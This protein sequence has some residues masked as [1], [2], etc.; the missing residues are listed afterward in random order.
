M[1]KVIR[2]KKKVVRS[3]KSSFKFRG[4]SNIF[5]IIA[6]VVVVLG[7]GGFFV[8]NQKSGTS[9]LSVPGM[10]AVTLNPNCEL[11]DP[12]LCKFMNNWVNQKTYA[13]TSTSSMGGESDESTME[14]DG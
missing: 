5:I 2:K 8:L 10:K 14:V 7:V 6:V 1:P 12:E 3:H 13:V 9:A 4:K 11:K